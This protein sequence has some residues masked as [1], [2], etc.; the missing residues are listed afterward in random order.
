MNL[1]K[2]NKKNAGI[3]PGNELL[4]RLVRRVFT[5]PVPG[6]QF[7]V[8]HHHHGSDA[9]DDTRNHLR[10]PVNNHFPHELGI[11]DYLLSREVFKADRPQYSYT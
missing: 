10:C 9:H 3:A 11:H 7:G 6:I 1:K 4:R 5:E 2:I 8:I